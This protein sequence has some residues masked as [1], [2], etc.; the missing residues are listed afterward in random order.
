MLY[1]TLYKF[2]LSDLMASIIVVLK[3]ISCNFTNE[4]V[5]F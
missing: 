5:I 3:E 2:V 4:K 1:N